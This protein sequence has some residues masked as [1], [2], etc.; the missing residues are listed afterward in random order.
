MVFGF[1]QLYVT[2]LL[3]IV[4]HIQNINIKEPS[5]KE[6][7]LIPN[8]NESFNLAVAGLE[9]IT[10]EGCMKDIVTSSHHF[11]ITVRLLLFCTFK[12]LTLRSSLESRC[13]LAGDFF[14]IIYFS[15]LKML[16]TK[17]KLPRVTLFGRIKVA[18]KNQ[19]K[20]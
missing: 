17:Q 15:N 1:F 11:N 14:S 9:L 10:L 12:T 19:P 8:Q 20:L 18:H 3:I 5:W 4:L 7:S 6:Y 13:S 2:V 16:K